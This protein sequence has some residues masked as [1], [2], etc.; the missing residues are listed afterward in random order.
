VHQHDRERKEHRDVD[1][2]EAVLV[3]IR[4]GVVGAMDRRHVVRVVAKHREQ[5]ER[6]GDR[7]AVF[8]LKKIREREQRKR[9]CAA[10]NQQVE[11]CGEEPR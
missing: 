9:P 10:T 1:R 7:R 2:E 3:K 6:E 4:R 11:W 8:A 5:V